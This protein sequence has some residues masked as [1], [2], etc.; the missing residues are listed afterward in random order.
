MTWI[1]TKRQRFYLH[2]SESLLAGL[3][4]TGHDINY[5]CKQGYCGSCRCTV[6]YHNRPITYPT[7]PIAHLKSHEILPCV[8]QVE[9]CLCLDLD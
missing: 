1:I 7:P 6:Q 4:R 5:Q 9:G 2:D 8:C 3:L